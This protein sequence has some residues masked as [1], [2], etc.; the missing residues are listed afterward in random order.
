MSSA[1]RS[2]NQRLSRP[3]ETAVADGNPRKDIHNDLKTASQTRLFHSSHRPGDRYNVNPFQRQRST[4]A[5]RISCPKNGEHLTI[6]QQLACRK[7]KLTLTCPFSGREISTDCSF[8]LPRGHGFVFYRFCSTEVFYLI[9]GYP[10]S[11]FSKIG[12]YFPSTEIIID[13]GQTQGEG[14]VA[15]A[16]NLLKVLMVANELLSKVVFRRL[17]QAAV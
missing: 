12:F 11:G 14:K 6:F 7:Q 8:V 5:T 13:R 2:K 16:V 1:A 9:T 4:L 10:W 17:I 15:A 3:V